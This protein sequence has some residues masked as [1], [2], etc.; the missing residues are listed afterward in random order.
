[1]RTISESLY[2]G[3]E[4]LLVM[5]HARKYNAFLGRLIRQYGTGAHTVVD[6]GAG[7]GALAG[8]VRL[9]ASRLVC[10]EPDAVQMDMLKAAGHEV[11]NGISV[12]PDASVDYVYSVNVLEHIDDDGAVLAEIYKV[13]RPG[14]RLLVYVPA[15]QWLYSSMDAAVGHVRRY[16]MKDLTNKVASAGFVVV[17]QE[18]VDS[19]GVPAS[20]VYKW[21]G[22][23]SGHINVKALSLY[24]RI[25]FPF[26]R[27]LDRL[28]G[29]I[30]GKNLLV[31]C[32]K[33]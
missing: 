6:F 18:Y 21:A 7:V 28:F 23:T 27:I 9:W 12:L 24:D 15:L 5:Q 10:V 2:A 31:V 1:M 25:V 26:S 30:A 3:H 29:R 22:D 32:E 19:L 4:N 33:P 11:E 20:L 8:D 16:H 14:G 17:R 13:L